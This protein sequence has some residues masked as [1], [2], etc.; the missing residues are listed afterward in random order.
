[1]SGEHGTRLMSGER[2][3]RLPG[4]REIRRNGRVRVTV[5]V[6]I[7]LTVGGT[8]GWSTMLGWPALILA[9]DLLVTGGWLVRHR[10]GGAR[11]PS[12]A[13]SGAGGWRAMPVAD[14]R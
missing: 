1:M 6:A 12:V 4:E 7:L 9:A 5:V 8:A 2:G 11:L 3:T 10:A 13:P 14:E